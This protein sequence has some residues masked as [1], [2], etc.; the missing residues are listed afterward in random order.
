VSKPPTKR[1]KERATT[2]PIVRFGFDAAFEVT[3]C[4]AAR[5]GW[6]TPVTSVVHLAENPVGALVAKA[7]FS[8]VVVV[9][10]SV[11]T[12]VYKERNS[13]KI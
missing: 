8:A 2:A 4:K 13:E 6:W 7:S 10:V 1:S 11:L 3:A 9:V 12:S 5:I